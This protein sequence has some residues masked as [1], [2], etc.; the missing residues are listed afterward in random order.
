MMQSVDVSTTPT[1][2]DDFRLIDLIDTGHRVPK[3]VDSEG[4]ISRSLPSVVSLI[5]ANDLG[6]GDWIPLSATGGQKMLQIP[7]ARNRAS[8]LVDDARV[9][10][11]MWYE[12]YSTGRTIQGAREWAVGGAFVSHFPTR[13]IRAVPTASEN[14]QAIPDISARTWNADLQALLLEE[15]LLGYFIKLVW[16]AVDE[17]F[18]DGMESAFSQAVKNVIG[19]YGDIAVYAIERLLSSQKANAETAGEIL[20]QIGSIEDSSTHRSRLTVLT[21]Q[22]KSPDP[23]IRDAASLGL[24]ALDDPTAI[25]DVQTA[26]KRESSPRLREN[27]KLVLDQ[28]QLTRWQGS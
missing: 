1:F 28:L 18:L 12:P 4:D 24:A 17:V 10:P 15:Q 2:V 3:D 19:G 22:L 9:Q 27:L 25:S 13:A 5:L 23:R 14:Y 21:D 7:L 20:R 16:E 8:S 6:I 11:F 26:L